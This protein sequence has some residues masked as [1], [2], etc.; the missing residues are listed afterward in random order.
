MGRELQGGGPWSSRE[1]RE[2]KVL[3]GRSE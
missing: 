1:R 2:K 3:G